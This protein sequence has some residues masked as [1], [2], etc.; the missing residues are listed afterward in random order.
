[1]HFGKRWWLNWLGKARSISVSS[2]WQTQCSPLAVHKVFHHSSLGWEETGGWDSPRF[3]TFSPMRYVAER[4]PW[5]RAESTDGLGVL[6][7]NH[8]PTGTAWNPDQPRC[9][10]A[11]IVVDLILLQRSPLSST[12]GHLWTTL[13]CYAPKNNV[14]FSL[15]YTYSEFIF[16]KLARLTHVY[17]SKVFY[18]CVCL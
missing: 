14:F 3:G 1:M 8:Y 11:L 5:L 16:N 15:F 9:G 4:H 10:L 7:M 6:I 18:V 2:T 13:Q 12:K 17:I